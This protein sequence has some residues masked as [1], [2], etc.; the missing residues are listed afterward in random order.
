MTLQLGYKGVLQEGG[1]VASLAKVKADG[2][3]CSVL[4]SPILLFHPRRQIRLIK[5]NLLSL[6]L[7]W[8]LLIII[9][10]MCSEMAFN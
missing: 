9:I 7:F 3:Y 5:Y 6:G 2:I 4:N 8:L 10:S 1:S